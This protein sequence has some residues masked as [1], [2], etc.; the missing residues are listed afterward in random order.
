M[1]ATTFAVA[2]C[3]ATAPDRAA[4]KRRAAPVETA[5]A[6]SRPEAEVR[7]LIEAWLGAIDTPIS[8]ASWRSLG[9]AARPLLRAVADDEHRL[10]TRR[11]RAV[12]ALAAFA[13]VDD[14]PAFEGMMLDE[15]AP[16]VVRLAA[17]RALA[18]GTPDA[19]LPAVLG[20]VLERP[21]D[22]RVRA[23]AALSLV[24]RLP[25]ACGALELRLR[26]EDPAERERF[27]AA[28]QQCGR[29]AQ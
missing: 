6:P 26:G 20:S 2:L 24:R 16:L 14:R 8:A 15:Q 18:A 10:P 25:S 22:V 28:L 5:A 9:P 23:H 12:G 27:G 1:I 4:Q 3:L 17:V 11:A 19:E 29:P 7:E 21:M 13:A